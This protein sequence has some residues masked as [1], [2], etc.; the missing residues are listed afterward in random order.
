MFVRSPGF[1]L[2]AVAALALGIGANTAIFSIVNAVLLKPVPF[3]EPD[4]LVVFQTDL[5]PGRVQR[6]LAGEVPVLARAD[7]RRPGRRPPTARTSSTSPATACPSSC[8]PSQ[9][10]AD[11]FRLFGAPILQGR[12]FTA[13]EDRPDGDAGRGAEPRALDAPLRRRSRA[14]S[15]RPSRS[16][17]N[18]TP[19]S[20]SSDPTF[21]F[22]SSG[23]SPMSGSRSRSTRT[24]AIRATTFGRRAA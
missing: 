8:A 20:A 14:S 24:P 15:A 22:A 7:R 21:D 18:R 23:R 16:A 9:V 10:S 6:R 5:A 13:D 2:A 3:P 4:R 11:Y 12:G 1:T 17:A 19:S